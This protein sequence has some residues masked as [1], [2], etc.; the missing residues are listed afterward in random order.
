MLKICYFHIKTIKKSFKISIVQI[1]LFIFDILIN[2]FYIL[3]AF[4]IEK[5]WRTH[6]AAIRRLAISQRTPVYRRRSGIICSR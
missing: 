2:G 5:K 4:L 1:N 3:I 6:R